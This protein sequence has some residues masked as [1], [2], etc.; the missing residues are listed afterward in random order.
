MVNFCAFTVI[1]QTIS[2]VIARKHPRYV[3][4]VE[5]GAIASKIVGHY[6]SKVKRSRDTIIMAITG[7]GITCNKTQTVRRDS[8]KTIMAIIRIV[9]ITT[10][11]IDPNNVTLQ[12]QGA[13]SKVGTPGRR[14]NTANKANSV[15]ITIKTMGQRSNTA[16]NEITAMLTQWNRSNKKIDLRIRRQHVLPNATTTRKHQTWDWSNLR[17][18]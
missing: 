3:I 4:I 7:H 14:D 5:R 17:H 2:S 16:I 8:N 10:A 6:R 18:M 13:L 15:G 12:R 9:G 11:P 1:V